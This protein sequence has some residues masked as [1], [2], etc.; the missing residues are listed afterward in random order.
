M[1]ARGAQIV[2]RLAGRRRLSSPS[3]GGRGAAR[4]RGRGRGKGR[5][6]ARGGR[7]KGRSR[8]TGLEAPPGA[9]VWDAQVHDPRP[10]NLGFVR[11][12]TKNEIHTAHKGGVEINA[13]SAKHGLPVDRIKAILMLKD[14]EDDAR[15]A[16]TVHEGLNNEFE[17]HATQFLKD[18]SG[19]YGVPVPNSHHRADTDAAASSSQKRLVALGEDDDEAEIRAALAEPAEVESAGVVAEEFVEVAPRPAEPGAFVFR[20]LDADTTKVVSRGGGERAADAADKAHRSWARREPFWDAHAAERR[21][22]ERGRKDE[23]AS[24]SEGVQS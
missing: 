24:S 10:L 4:G 22:A 16:G 14:L 1:S 11:D 15:Q 18:V 19:H 2:G 13:L 21:W 23:D 17:Q 7:G 5:G 3:G 20:D 12:A 6:A 8:G 9:V